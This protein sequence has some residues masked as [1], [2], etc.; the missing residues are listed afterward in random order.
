LV[1]PKN[2]NADIDTKD[3]QDAASHMGVELPIVDAVSED[4]FEAAFADIVQKH[5]DALIVVNDALFLSRPERIIRLAMQNRVPT[6]YVGRPYVGWGGLISYG[7]DVRVLYRETGTYVGRVLKGGSPSNLPV[8]QPTRFEL[9]INLKTAKAL[10]LT[11]P[12]S[13]LARADEVIE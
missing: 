4:G 6:M 11:V 5:A 12:P 8:L 13:L 3:M 1:N 7:T 2:P 9:A 10:A